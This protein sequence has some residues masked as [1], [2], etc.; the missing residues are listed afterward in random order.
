MNF[1]KREEIDKK[2]AFLF[3]TDEIISTKKSGGKMSKKELMLLAPIGCVRSPY[4]KT[5]DIPI[6]RGISKIEILDDYI[7][8]LTGLMSSSHAIILGYLFLAN[9]DTL[10]AS[11]RLGERENEAKGIFSVRSSARPNPI[12]FTVAKLLE[13]KNGVIKV[14][15]LDFIDGT[16]IIDIKPYSPGWDSVHCATRVRRVSFHEMQPEK[17][18]GLL[19]RDA[20]N[21]SGKLDNKGL[22]V[23]A[24]VFLLATKYQIDPR[25]PELRMEINRYGTT[26]DALIGMCGVTFGSGRI[27]VLDLRQKF[28]TCRFYWKN[29][30]LTMEAKGARKISGDLTS[31]E[32]ESLIGIS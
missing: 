22:M 27:K 16:P 28:L 9:R 30:S 25:D 13:V 17:S 24:M 26:L 11:L 2:M 31:E 23:V 14:E 15:G 12:G 20:I 32:A 29:L 5:N 8:G 3:K 18:L 1:N 21:F 7:P 10:K 19:L 4:K 6:K